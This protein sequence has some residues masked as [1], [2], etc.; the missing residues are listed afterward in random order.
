MVVAAERAATQAERLVIRSS[1][2]LKSLGRVDD[3]PGII[4]IRIM[5][6]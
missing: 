1:A 3:S 2:S 6:E 5:F 4:M